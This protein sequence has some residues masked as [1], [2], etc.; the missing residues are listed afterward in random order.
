MT[1]KAELRKQAEE[2]GLK[3]YKNATKAQIQKEID[4]SKSFARVAE[5]MGRRKSNSKPLWMMN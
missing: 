4:R 5:Q 2:M 3:L 1:T